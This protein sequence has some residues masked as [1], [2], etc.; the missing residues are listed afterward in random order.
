MS[1]LYSPTLIDKILDKSGKYP[2]IIEKS[3]R[4]IISSPSGRNIFRKFMA[5]D[6]A[7]NSN[8]LIAHRVSTH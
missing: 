6:L 4:Y 1:N 7:P 2:E 8:D 3:D 5:E